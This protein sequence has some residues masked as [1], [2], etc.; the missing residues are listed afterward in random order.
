MHFKSFVKNGI[1]LA[2]FFLFLFQPVQAQQE[3][4]GWIENVRLLSWDTK[5]RAK[6]DTGARTSSLYAINIEPFDKEG[7]PWVKFTLPKSAIRTEGK[8]QDIHME[9]PVI[10][11]TKI[12]EHVGESVDRYV[13]EI[14]LCINGKN[15]TTPVTLA[16]R[17]NFNYPLLLGRNI[18]KNHFLVDAGKTFTSTKSCLHNE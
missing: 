2:L 8:K 5:V 11:E 4:L 16:D 9:K 10:R 12:K 6:L 3:T 7:E 18:L 1:F 14:E 13:V 15:Y 17:S